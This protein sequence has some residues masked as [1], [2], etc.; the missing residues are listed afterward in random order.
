MDITPETERL[1]FRRYTL[2]DLDRIAEWLS[3]EEMTRYY[4]GEPWPQDR[5]VEWLSGRILPT[6]AERGHGYWVIT[7]KETGEPVGHTGLMLQPLEG[8]DVY[9]VGYFLHKKFWR[10]GLATEAAKAA[11]DHCFEVLDLDEISSFIHPDNAASI[12]VAEKNGLTFDRMAVWRD[13]P[14]RIYMKRR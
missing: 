14:T 13:L 10:Q 8:D 2:D 11:Y 7:L 3:D 9:E 1:H 4:G 5:V 6:W 12:R